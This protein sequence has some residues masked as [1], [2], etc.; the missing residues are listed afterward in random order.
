[1]YANEAMSIAQWSEIYNICKYINR[2]FMKTQ[3]QDFNLLDRT[4]DS[5]LQLAGQILKSIQ[6]N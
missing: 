1:M 2:F 5:L 4:S 3:F 6:I